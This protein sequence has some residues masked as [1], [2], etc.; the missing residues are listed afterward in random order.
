[1]ERIYF[2]LKGDG[3]ETKAIKAEEINLKKISIAWTEFVE[4]HA[5]GHDYLHD[6]SFIGISFSFDE[7]KPEGWCKAEN[8][9]GIFRPKAN[10]CPEAY[11]EWKGLPRI[12]FG[13]SL[14]NTLGAKGVLKPGARGMRMLWLTYKKTEEGYILSCP[15][16]DKGEYYKPKGEHEELTPTRFIELTKKEG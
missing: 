16:S 7:P 8:R 12:P 9:S 6:N 14:G 15:I 10:E 3:P 4:K 11:K 13:D 2:L 5:P 1:M